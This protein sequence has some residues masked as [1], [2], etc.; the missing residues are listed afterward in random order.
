MRIITIGFLVLI[1]GCSSPSAL[2]VEQTKKESNLET[3]EEIISKLSSDKFEGRKP[4][5]NGFNLASSY[6]ESFLSK[7]KIQPYFE[8]SYKDTVL[9]N[10]KESY[11]IVG[12]IGEHNPDKKYILLGAHLDHLGKIKG[13]IYNGAN[14]DASGVTAVLQIAKQLRQDK[15]DQNIIVALF[16]GE[17]SG[18]IGS[19]HLAEKLKK[20]NINLTYMLN[21]EM[22]GKIL[23]T[24]KNQVYLT[25]YSK[26]NCAE[27]MNKIMD[28]KF[29]YFLPAEITQNLFYRSD[30]Y[31]FYQ[32]FNVPSHTISTFDFENYEHYHK[33]SDDVEQLDIENMANI[34]DSSAFI[35]SRLLRDNIEL[36]N[37]ESG[38]N[39]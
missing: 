2:S 36:M 17:E 37:T 20:E 25:G 34:I 6:V 28:N 7:N 12:L 26:S 10:G 1:G 29:V 33:E 21:F 24:G 23:T 35:I 9:V 3:T 14:D 15:F 4:G 16:T 38:T 8:G 11:N 18:L 13:S 19:R 22:I 31:A 32:A 5:T 39:N 30:N 27:E